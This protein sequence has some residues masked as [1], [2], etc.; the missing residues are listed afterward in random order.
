[1]CRCIHAKPDLITLILSRLEV[2]DD[3]CVNELCADGVGGAV[4]PWG[5]E[6]F[7]ET[8]APRSSLLLS[9]LPPLLLLTLRDGIQHM[10]PGAA[11]RPVLHTQQHT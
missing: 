6:L 5:E 3:L 1:M 4:M 10:I 11:Y 2:V 8:E 7:P 9:P